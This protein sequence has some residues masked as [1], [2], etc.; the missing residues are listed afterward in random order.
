MRIPVSGALLLLEMTSLGLG[1]FLSGSLLFVEAPPGRLVQLLPGSPT[2][3]PSLPGSAV[4]EALPVSDPY[5]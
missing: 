3:P 1:S 2:P 5:I 4:S